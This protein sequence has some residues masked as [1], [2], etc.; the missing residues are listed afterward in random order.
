MK[1]NLLMWSLTFAAMFAFSISTYAQHGAAGGGGGRPA[2]AGGAAGA[3]GA[4][5]GGARGNSGGAADSGSAGMGHANMDSQSPNTVLQNSRL[6]T[7]LSNAL[8]KSGVSVPGGNLQSACTG[9]K[10]LGQCVAAIHVANNLNIPGGFAALKGEMTGS[11]SLSLGKAIQ[12][13]SPEANA[14]AESKKGNK[15]TK[16]DLSAAESQM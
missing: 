4:S 8:S 6:N 7:S 16:H 1:K 2:G 14:K 15:Q 11:N 10:T 3:A 12:D 13:L 9:F 5:S